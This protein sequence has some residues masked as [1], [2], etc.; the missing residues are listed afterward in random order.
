[1]KYHS[2]I[3]G[4]YHKTIKYPEIEAEKSSHTQSNPK[5]CEQPWRCH[6]YLR[7]NCRVAVT[8]EHGTGVK[9]DRPTERN[10]GPRNQLTQLQPCDAG[11][12]VSKGDVSLLNTWVQL[13]TVV[14]QNNPDS[15]NE[16]PVFSLKYKILGKRKDMER[17][18]GLFEI[19]EPKREKNRAVEGKLHSYV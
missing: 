14:R 8:K 5:Q 7:S 19:F 10:K 12:F 2:N 11:V 9:H 6:K 18:E 1:M 4:I 13:E 16:N 17:K 3:T 15:E